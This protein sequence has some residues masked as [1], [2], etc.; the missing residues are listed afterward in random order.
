MQR[1]AD[2]PREIAKIFGAP[3]DRRARALELVTEG[4]PALPT[5]AS[6]IPTTYQLANH[7]NG[8]AASPL[9]GLRLDE[10][11][12]ATGGYDRFPFDFDASGSTMALAYDGADSLCF[13]DDSVH[14]F[15]T[16]M[17]GLDTGSSY[18]NLR[19]FGAW[20][21]DFLYTDNLVSG[22]NRIEVVG[23]SAGNPGSI[24]PLFAV[25]GL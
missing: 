6:V 7:P 22:G 4:C 3:Q 8:S 15:G 21:V 17:G 11:I 19:Y 20:E 13:A 14:I 1:R 2:E 10:L 5:S 25:G 23:T 9:Y 12:D 24:R 18:G 16:V